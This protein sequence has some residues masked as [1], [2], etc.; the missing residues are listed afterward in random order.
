MSWW[1]DLFGFFGSSSTTDDSCAVNP[2]NGLP[3]VGGCAGL[4]IEGNPYGCDLRA[5]GDLLHSCPGDDTWG[6]VS[7]SLIDSDLSWPDDSL[8]TSSSNWDD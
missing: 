4:D 6:D 8:S 1:N 2:A 5:H 7:S 3:M